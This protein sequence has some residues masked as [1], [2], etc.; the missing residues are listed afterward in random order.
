MVKARGQACD[1]KSAE[2]GSKLSLS[3][4]LQHNECMS[5][6]CKAMCVLTFFIRSF[7]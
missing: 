1:Y 6:I 7:F 4:P 5:V 2:N 3:S